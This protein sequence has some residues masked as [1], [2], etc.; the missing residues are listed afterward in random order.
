[1]NRIT[2]E[3]GTW[4]QHGMEFTLVKAPGCIPEVQIAH[5]SVTSRW[6]DINASLASHSQ[7]CWDAIKAGG[8]KKP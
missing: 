8:T 7:E 4:T 5:R 3:P 6:W 2:W 1:M